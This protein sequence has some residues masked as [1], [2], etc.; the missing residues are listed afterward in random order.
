VLCALY[1]AAAPVT[2]HA[3]L[4]TT[5]FGPFYDGILHL[6]LSLDDLLAVLAMALLAGLGGS[7]H[8]R[9]TLFTLAPAWLGAGLLGLNVAEIE[10][11]WPVASALSFLAVGLLVV[12]NRGLPLVAVGVLA[13]AIGSLHGFLNGTTMAQMDGET[14]TLVGIA[15]AVFAIVA[16]V[17]AFVT[18]LRAAWAVVA[19]RVVGGFI[20]AIGLLTLAWASCSQV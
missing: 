8:G 4:V 15:A 3:H 5:G 11:S 9:V 12:I 1:L 16:L 20:V 17:A 2:A 13:V 6:F 19:V 7:R 10:V 18:S 14:L